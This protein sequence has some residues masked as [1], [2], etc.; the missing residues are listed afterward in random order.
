MAGSRNI[1]RA[2]T[3]FLVLWLVHGVASYLFSN[4][5]GLAY[6]DLDAVSRIGYVKNLKSTGNNDNI[7]IEIGV[8]FAVLGVAWALI[9]LRKPFRWFDWTAQCV[10][11]LLQT[12]YLISIEVGSIRDSL[13]VDRNMV[14]LLWMTSYSALLI[15]LAITARQNEG[16]V[17]DSF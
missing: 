8:A 12:L 6:G 16:G 2:S 3:L 5:N 9:R 1:S 10:L 11:W 7:A 17:R 13:I 4:S 15:A 14:L